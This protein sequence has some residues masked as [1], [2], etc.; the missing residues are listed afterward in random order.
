MLIELV[1]R[2]GKV[3][4]IH[5]L[6]SDAEKIKH[7]LTRRGAEPDFSK[8]LELD[9]N[10]RELIAQNED[11]RQ[12]LNAASKAIG[13]KRQK[14]KDATAEMEA[15]KSLKEV[16]AQTSEKLNQIDQALNAEELNFPN[17]PDENCPEGLDESANVEI[18]RWGDIPQL[19][20]E[21]IAHDD[22]GKSLH[23]MDQETGVKL[24]KSRFTLLRGSAARMERALINFMLDTHTSNGYEEI[25]A[26]FV[27]NSKSLTGTG[28]L[29]KFAED[30]FKIDKEDLYLIPTAEVPLT[31]MYSDTVLKNIEKGKAL[32]WTAFTPCFRSEAGSYGKDTKGYIRQHQFNKV[33]LV[34]LCHPDDAEREHELLTQDAESILKALKL[35]YRKVD[36][37]AGDL[38]FSAKRTFD[39]EVWLPSKNCYREISSCSNFGD[40]QARRAGIRYKDKETK[41]NSFV[42]TLNGSG[43][44]VG[45][46]LVAIF[47]NYQTKNGH[48]IVPDALMPYMG[49]IEVISKN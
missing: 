29:P 44:A 30:L 15:T 24:A 47:E 14:G 40:F 5:Q 6:R 37:C 33:E 41:K 32:K 35:P 42:S 49:G 1:R 13:M 11:K 28:Q 3:L 20:F 39:L 38:G 36:L 10:R 25:L 2:L 4:D 27:A 43:L 22:L 16:I 9:E 19:N 7:A 48:I 45:R 26:P 34:K 18:Y 23:V 46:T 8:V 31:N 21:A 12:E 17:I